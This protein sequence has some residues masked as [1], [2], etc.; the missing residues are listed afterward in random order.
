[1]HNMSDEEVKSKFIACITRPQ[2]DKMSILAESIA[3]YTSENIHLV[4]TSNEFIGKMKQII[5][6]ENIV[7][8][9]SDKKSAGDC[10][11]ARSDAEVSNLISI[12]LRQG[13]SPIKV[14]ICCAHAKR[15]CE[16]IPDILESAY[17]N[18]RFMHSNINFVIHIDN[19]D[20]YIP[21][22]WDNIELLNLSPFV[23]EIVGYS[24]KVNGRWSTTDFYGKRCILR[25]IE[26]P[27]AREIRNREICAIE[28]KMDKESGKLWKKFKV[29]DGN[30]DAEWEKAHQFYE[31]ILGKRICEKSMPKKNDDG[32]YCSDSSASRVQLVSTFNN[33]KDEKWSN[34]FQLK[35]GCLS[36]AHVF[37]GYE[38]VDESSEY[39]IFIKFV[40]LVDNETT[41]EFL[42]KHYGTA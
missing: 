14:V 18:I 13:H 31:S 4:L 41:R 40:E 9:N 2:E 5:A 12:S 6:P 20:K 39:T 11:H 35:N 22:C 16:S 1:M 7:V 21:E 10:H 37:V 36:Y 38:N 15:I 25:E 28:R 23:S 32:F 30:E 3:M 34:R 8:F 29:Y 27:S 19:A 17:N 24:S 42:A 26:E 33:L